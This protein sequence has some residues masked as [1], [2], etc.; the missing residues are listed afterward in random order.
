M[1]S[2]IEEMEVWK[3]GCRLA[4]DVYKLTE[5][6]SLAKDWGMRDQL[7][8]SVVSIP[9]NIAEGFE[10]NSQTEFK[11]FLFIAKGSCAELRTQLYIIKAMGAISGN[12]IDPLL[13]GA[14][15]SELGQ[16]A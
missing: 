11:R 7:R 13:R 2:R 9:S 10:R 1:I 14:L 15:Y 12:R 8:R 6:E 16:A 5:E 4:V 3:K